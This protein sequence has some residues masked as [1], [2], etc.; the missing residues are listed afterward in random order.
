MHVDEGYSK[1]GP[2]CSKRQLGAF[3][4]KPDPASPPYSKPGPACSK[5]R[6]KP[7][8]V[9]YKEPIVLERPSS[10]YRPPSPV[11]KE[12]TYIHD[13]SISEESQ[14]AGAAALSDED[15]LAQLSS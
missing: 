1:P 7:E 3:G 12:R 6:A 8:P 10:P 13:P 11:Y 15:L 14:K 5:R 2:A 9:M 4:I